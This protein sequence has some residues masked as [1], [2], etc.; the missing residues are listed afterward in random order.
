MAIILR[1]YYNIHNIKLLVTFWYIF[2]LEVLFTFDDNFR[3]DF[4]E[5]VLRPADCYAEQVIALVK[6]AYRDKTLKNSI[7][8]TINIIGTIRWHNGSFS[9]QSL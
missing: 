6:N 9:K 8:T 4:R 1:T 7:G 3:N 5:E 2:R